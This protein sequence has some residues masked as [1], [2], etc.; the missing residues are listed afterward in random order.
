MKDGSTPLKV[1]NKGIYNADTFKRD[2]Y[3]NSSTNKTIAN[4][5]IK[6]YEVNVD[7]YI[8]YVNPPKIKTLPKNKGK[9]A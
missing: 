7:D 6:T 3:S 2:Y 5:S 4:Y 9:V 1:F 8:D